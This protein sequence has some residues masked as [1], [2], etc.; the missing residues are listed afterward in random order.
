MIDRC[1]ACHQPEAWHWEGHC[2][3][4]QPKPK[5]SST[6]TAEGRPRPRP[7]AGVCVEIDG[8]NLHKDGEWCP[9]CRFGLG[10]GFWSEPTAK[11]RSAQDT[12]SMR[13]AGAIWKKEGG[14]A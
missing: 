1:P 13:R 10:D 9:D 5:E 11:P 14:K 6:P 3:T 7:V 8:G 12:I 4:P 2:P